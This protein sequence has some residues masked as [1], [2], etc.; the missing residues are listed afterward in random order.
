[1][2][3]NTCKISHGDSSKKRTEKAM[4]IMRM[5]QKGRTGLQRMGKRVIVYFF[6]GDNSISWKKKKST[7]GCTISTALQW[8]QRIT[9][10][11]KNYIRTPGVT[12]FVLVLSYVCTK[13]IAIHRTGCALALVG[14]RLCRLHTFSCCVFSIYKIYSC[15]TIRPSKE[16]SSVSNSLEKY[17]KFL[18]DP[19]TVTS[20]TQ[21]AWDSPSIDCSPSTFHRKLLRRWT[22]QQEQSCFVFHIVPETRRKFCTCH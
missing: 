15:Q 16:L 13:V 5:S 11:L 19:P 18:S 12:F 6:K 14:L 9:L 7:C 4:W 10:F 20:P 2:N 1:M 22:S 3:P 17:L 8:E 21:I